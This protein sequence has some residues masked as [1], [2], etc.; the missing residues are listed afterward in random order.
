MWVSKSGCPRCRLMLIFIMAFVFIASNIHMVYHHGALLDHG[1]VV[2]MPRNPGNTEEARLLLRR[3]EAPRNPT[4]EKISMSSS[5]EGLLNDVDEKRSTSEHERDGDLVSAGADEADATFKEQEPI[6]HE[7]REF[8]ER[9]NQ[10]ITPPMPKSSIAKLFVKLV[11]INE[12]EVSLVS[13][14]EKA[15][16]A[17]ATI[18]VVPTAMPTLIAT[19]LSAR[20]LGLTVVPRV[21]SLRFVAQ[22]MGF[23]KISMLF[24][25]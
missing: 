13:A 7:L 24:E 11:D 10:E 20:R 8:R 17:G 15:V 1:A 2:L 6:D 18:A 22:A 21:E 3:G 25:R 4:T 16:F 5:D 19:G 12:T 9:F 23:K 14:A